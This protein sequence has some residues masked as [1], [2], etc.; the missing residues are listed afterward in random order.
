MPVFKCVSMGTLAG[1]AW[2]TTFSRMA[3]DEALVRIVYE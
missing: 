2:L 1:A 3:C